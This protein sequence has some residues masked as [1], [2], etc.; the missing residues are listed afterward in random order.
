MYLPRGVAQPVEFI[1][2]LNALAP[3]P[4]GVVNLRYTVENDWSGDPA[5]F[6][7]ITLADEAAHPSIL[8]ETTRRISDSSPGRSTRPVNGAS[9]HTSISEA[10]PSRRS[11]RKRSSAD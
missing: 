8:P 10:N 1:K 11:S 3:F 2:R 5:V 9:F 6:F 4:R 7:W